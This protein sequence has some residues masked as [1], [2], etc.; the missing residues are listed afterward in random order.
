MVLECRQDSRPKVEELQQ[1][2][3]ADAQRVFCA[4]DASRQS[5]VPVPFGWLVRYFALKLWRRLSPPSAQMSRKPMAQRCTT[6]QG[7][8]A[9]LP[10]QTALSLRLRF[11]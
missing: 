5:W 2:F 7:K 8:D 4:L 11:R 6:G 10:I 9:S 1:R 3:S